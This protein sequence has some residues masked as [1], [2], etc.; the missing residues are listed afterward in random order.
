MN[1][2]ME[3]A[4]TTG[5]M[6]GLISLFSLLVFRP[7]AERVRLLDIPDQR[8]THKGAVPLIG[9]LS[10]F[11]G[12]FVAWLIAMPFSGG[13]GIFLLCSLL[14][15][16]LGAVDDARHL[17]AAFRLW[18][19]VTLGAL[20]VYG[21]GVSLEHFGNLFGLGAIELG[22][23]GPLITIA[24]V[25]GATNAF[26]MM[27]GIDG[28]AGSMSLV[29]LVSLLILFVGAPGFGAETTLSIAIILALVPYMM[30]NLRVPPFEKRIFMGDA[31]A[32]FIGFSVVWLLTKGAQ[33][34]QA[35]FRPVTALWIIAIPLMDMVSIMVRRARKGLSVMKADRDHLHHIFLRAGLSDRQALVV[36][37]LMA[38]LL[39]SI[40]LIG[41]WLAVPGWLMFGGFLG[42]FLLYQWSLRHAWRLAVAARQRLTRT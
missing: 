14:L 30:A 29:G 36:I 38:V 24:A 16:L 34:E 42:V 3:M 4:G 41:E 31:G 20:L 6:A 25:I 2:P 37:T 15:V 5:L 10:A 19:Q 17:P 18:A 33:M 23:T 22:W 13:Y 1:V 39:A 12:L 8:K 7:L 21:S 40:G 26:N 28:L 27:D 32:L 11:A 35:A 9:G